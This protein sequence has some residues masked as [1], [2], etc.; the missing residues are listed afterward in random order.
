MSK[1]FRVGIPVVLVGVIALAGA[2]AAFAQSG[3][4]QAD[5]TGWGAGRG[6]GTGLLAAYDEAIHAELAKALGMSV[7][8]FEAA[9][10]DGVTL[11]ALA[12][13]NDVPLE[14]LQAVMHEARAEAIKD[15]LADGAITQEQADWL[16]E[17]GAMGYG[18]GTA[19]GLCDGTGPRGAGG[20]GPR[21]AGGMGRAGR[22]GS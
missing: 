3:T 4:T 22:T 6:P 21:G 2:T 7:E 16:L 18:P 17:R 8:E 9:R 11:A 10:A 19:Q 20:M 5:A 1:F 14:D 13:E 15:A 12:A